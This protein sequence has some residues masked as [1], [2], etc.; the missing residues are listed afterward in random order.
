MSG[1]DG[2]VSARREVRAPASQIFSILATPSRHPDFD[3]SGM[4][5]GAEGDD[6][7]TGVGSEFLMRM[8]LEEFSDYVMKNTVVEFEQDR[9]LVWEPERHD[10]EDEHWHYRWGFEL[11]PT[12]RDV[13]TVTEF[14]DCSRSPD[15]ARVLLKDGEVWRAAIERSLERLDAM[16]TGGAD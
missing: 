6:V 14:Y 8:Y 3:G 1:D 13:T 11:E 9:R 7:L 16:A 4:L 12:A 15:H 10:Q 5:R 2:V